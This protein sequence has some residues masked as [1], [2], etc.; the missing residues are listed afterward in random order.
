MR[1]AYMLTSLGRGGAERQVLALAERMA[2]RGHHVI[3]MIL[4][5]SEVDEWPPSLE[6]IRLDMR[7]SLA[8]VSAGL[9]R[10]RRHLR[11]FRPEIVHSHTFPANMAAR[12]LHAF[13]STPAVLSTIHNIYEGRWWRTVLYR[14]TDILAAHTTAVSGGGGLFS[15]ALQTS[16]PLTPL[17]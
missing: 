9:L 17:R 10:G 3:L 7:K 2:A 5:P 6:V 15:I 4:K 14:V 16:W 13:H 1:I 12:I 11:R 8:G